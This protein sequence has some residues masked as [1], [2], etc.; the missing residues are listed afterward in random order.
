MNILYIAYSCDPYCGSEDKI[1]WNIPLAASKLHKVFVLTKEEHRESITKFCAEN[2]IDNISFYFADINGIFKKIF[3][4]PFYSGRLNIWHKKALPI[5]KKIC[6]ENN[7]NIIHQ[8]A[9]IEFRSIGKYYKIP[10]T[11]FVC[12]PIAGGQDVPKPLMSYLGKE[13]LLEAFRK[14]LN[15][16]YKI[17]IQAS[18]IL[19]KCSCVIYANNETKEYLEPDKNSL[20]IPD[21]A[22]NESELSQS[23]SENEK[24]GD[25]I[26]LTAGRFI[27]TKGYN[28]L[29]DAL[30]QI[31]DAPNFKIRIIGSGPLENNLKALFASDEKVNSHTE[32]VG[33]LPF[34][35]MN[36]QYQSA[37]AFVFPSFREATG[38]VILEAMANGTP[39]I[40]ENRCGG[41][42]ICC[43]ENAYFYSGSTK[44]E[45]IKSLSSLM[46][47]CINN[48]NEVKEKGKEARN[49]AESFTFEKRVDRYTKIYES[50]L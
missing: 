13:K 29:F 37:D 16:I 17:K 22:L 8:I 4:P 6:L 38:S 10:G 3:K 14:F 18:G 23:V 24:D 34:S 44:E 47:H 35:E 1:G 19:K 15:R 43:D 5:A 2:N 21:T 28:L 46:L 42:V 48:P 36:A 40:T 30:K 50:L 45:Y 7:I 25:F 20:V 11:K 33:K 27:A 32:F 31:K 41:P 49:A 39:V 9:P 26:F 12:G